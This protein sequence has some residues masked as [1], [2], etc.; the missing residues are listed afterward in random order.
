MDMKR[1]AGRIVPRGAARLRVH[2]AHWIPALVVVATLAVL[3]WSAWPAVR[4]MR[5]VEVV[6][7]VFDRADVEATPAQ[8]GFPT[9][10]A[11]ERAQRGG[12]RTVQAAGWLEPE[13]YPIACTALADGVVESIEALAGER[14]E[15]GDVVARLVDED[16]RL[17]LRRAE[18]E[19]SV[20][21]SELA[22]AQA[23]LA[24]ARTRWDEPVELEQAVEVG[25]AS[26]AE[27]RAELALLPALVDAAR[28]TLLRLEEELARAEESRARG[29]ATEF[30]VIVARQHAAAQRAEVSALEG[31]GPLLEA[32]VRRLE[33]QLRAAERNLDLR[34]EDR[35]ALDSAGASV[36]RAEAA[37]NRLRAQR[38]E[39]ALELE[40]MVIRAPITGYVQRRL[41]SPGDKVVRMMDDPASAQLAHLYDPERLQVR[42][43]VPLADSAYVFAG[44]RCE[45]VVEAMPD[46][47]FEGVVLRT[48]HEADLQ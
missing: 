33:A 32:R 3:A 26:L 31:R 30:E 14:V 45:V 2:A 6:Q 21:E 20:A 15:A 7:A 1:R 38:D 22:V 19:L 10:A 11:P 9:D 13:P 27:S 44:Q 28:A 16:S 25:R 42:V 39:A 4:P 48:T 47:T 18:A 8:D 40:R 46:T 5:T 17:R 41:K 23:E 24:A 37:V 12:G 34:I 35:R 43:D 36:A 29:A